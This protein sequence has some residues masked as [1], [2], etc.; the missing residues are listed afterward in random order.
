[1]VN[2]KLGAKR[3]CKKCSA[4]FYDLN[5]DPMTCPKCGKSFDAQEFSSK[6]VKTSGRA[7]KAEAQVE[8]VFDLEMEDAEDTLDTDDEIIEADLD[9]DE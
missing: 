6:Y 8:E 9:E 2:P 5:K 1:M 7:Q 3:I 4:P